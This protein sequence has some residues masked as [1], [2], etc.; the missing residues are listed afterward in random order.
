[1]AAF[2]EKASETKSKAV[3]MLFDREILDRIMQHPIKQDSENKVC[4]KYQGYSL[5]NRDDMLEFIDAGN[6]K[7]TSMEKKPEEK[8]EEKKEKT[9]ERTM[10][11]KISRV[12]I[13]AQNICKTLNYGV[14]E[15]SIKE[16]FKPN[17]GYEILFI[18]KG[19]NMVGFLIARRGACQRYPGQYMID[20]VCTSVKGI[21]SLLLGACMFAIKTKPM[22][23]AYSGVLSTKI[24]LSCANGFDNQAA[25][26]SYR[27]MGFS[28][29]HDLFV[30]ETDGVTCIHEEYADLPM[31]VDVRRTTTDEIVQLM[32]TSSTKK[33]PMCDR[34][35]SLEALVKVVDGSKALDVGSTEKLRE[36]IKFTKGEINIYPYI[37]ALL[38]YGHMENHDV[39]VRLLMDSVERGF[40]I[41]PYALLKLLNDCE[42][43]VDGGK[44]RLSDLIKLREKIVLLH[45][46]DYTL[47]LAFAM[48][49]F[50]EARKKNYE[51]EGLGKNYSH[52]SPPYL[53]LLRFIFT[54]ATGSIGSKEHMDDV[55]RG[56]IY[57]NAFLEIV[58]DAIRD[59][60]FKHDELHQNLL[61]SVVNILT[62][63]E[64]RLKHLNSKSDTMSAEEQIIYTNED[65]DYV[66]KIDEEMKKFHGMYRPPGEGEPETN[67]LLIKIA[68]KIQK[69]FGE[70]LEEYSS[71]K[72]LEEYSSLKGR[73]SAY[74]SPK[75][76]DGSPPSQKKGRARSTSP[77]TKKVSSSSEKKGRAR[78][79][80]PKTKKVLPP[81]KKKGSTY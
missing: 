21:S 42:E 79:S 34:R 71:L 54:K 66:R 61:K 50:E 16:S 64:D 62:I 12:I 81:S 77:K 28:I 3:H 45:K 22:I 26:C 2:E 51:K 13:V 15:I 4:D 35:L 52:R 67:C 10:E 37:L 25:Y 32:V 36:Y 76:P 60:R 65:N 69:L 73:V 18:M 30:T 47:R 24:M 68:E 48:K 33:D 43:V 7:Q 55:E 59:N 63:Q 19:S 17:S 80:S 40:R 56:H 31:S 23:P 58:L 29:D 6:K 1:M 72:D 75:T 44:K 20:F 53:S 57:Y 5:F 8:K 49:D 70:Y 46:M 9:P 39:R 78:S 14:I 38:V 74:S 11:E 41:Y 27:K